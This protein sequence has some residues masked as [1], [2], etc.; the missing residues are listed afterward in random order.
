MAKRVRKLT[1]TDEEYGAVA[2]FT[3]MV[4]TYVD[5]SDIFVDYTQDG[6]EIHDVS[7]FRVGELPLP[8]AEDMRS[9]PQEFQNTVYGIAYQTLNR[10]FYPRLLLRVAIKRR[11]KMCELN[12]NAPKVTVEMLTDPKYRIILFQT[13]PRELLVDMIDMLRVIV[14]A[15]GELIIHEDEQAGSGIFFLLQGT[16]SVIKKV[17]V[18]EK[19]SKSLGPESTKQLVVLNPPVCFGEFA[20][21]TEEPRLAS[22]RAVSN[23][24][25]WVLRK[26]DFHR[27]FARLPK[28]KLTSVIK[29]AFEKR[30][31]ALHMNYPVTNEFLRSFAMF[32]NCP[33]DVLDKIRSKCTPNAVPKKFTLYKRGDRAQRIYFLRNGKVGL[34]R[35]MESGDNDGGSPFE[36]RANKEIHV[37]SLS[38]N[39]LFGETDVLY[40]GSYENTVITTTNCDLWC[41]T[42]GD[43]DQAVSKSPEIMNRM[44]EDA[45]SDRESSLNLQ[46]VKFRAYINEIPILSSMINAFELRALYDK[47]EPRIYKPN[48]LLTSTAFFAD[49]LIILTKGT[50]RVGQ[51]GTFEVGECIGYTCVVPHRWSVPVSSLSIVEVIELRMEHFVDFLTEKGLIDLYTEVCKTLMFPR[52]ASESAIQDAWQRVAKFKTPIVFPMSSSNKINPHEYK[53]GVT[54]PVNGAVCANTRKNLASTPS[55]KQTRS[56]KILEKIHTRSQSLPPV[57]DRSRGMFTKRPISRM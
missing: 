37:K 9:L 25:L 8:N 5:E 53:F 42:V 49:R 14:F 22:V 21:L 16:V 54:S 20:F 47:F 11:R 28:E 50:A 51:I 43:I 23:V 4:R 34:Y 55:V 44:L 32:K 33:D 12:K 57:V 30:N 13:W 39:S 38:G 2:E 35:A 27:L 46:Q 29:V 31:Q 56:S 24:V 3:R 7:S 6:V 52:A 19:K 18:N 48:H 17:R 40:N 45:R 1:T 41:L 15:S 10:L 26:A 36:P